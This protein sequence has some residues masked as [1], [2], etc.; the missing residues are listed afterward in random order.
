MTNGLIS[1]VERVDDIPLLLAQMEKIQLA[2]LLDNHFPMHGHWKGLGLGHIVQVWLAYILSEGDHR[3]NHV[4]SWAD[5]LQITLAKCLARPVRSLDFT[6]DRL[7]I[8]LDSLG[9]DDDFEAFERNLNQG[10][11]RVYDLKAKRV[12]VDSTSASGYM[13]V[14]ENGLF[15]FGHSKDHR[16]DLPQLKINQSALD[17]LGIPLTTTIVS[18][19]KA[20]D[21]LYIP[22]IRK[23]QNSLLEHGVLYVGDCK[24]ASLATRAYVAKSDDFYLCPL[25]SVQMPESELSLLLDKIWNNEQTLTSIYRPAVD[26][27]DDP[28]QIAEG[29]GYTIHLESDEAG[30]HFSWD[31]QRLVVRSLN[32]ARKQE[33]TLHAHIKEAQTVIAKLN[34]R[35]RGIK[36]LDEKEMHAAVDTILKKYKLQSLLQIEYRREEK[37]TLQK[38]T[39]KRETYILVETSITVHSTLNQDALDKYVRNLGWRVYACNDPALSIEEAVL[40]YRQEYLIEHGFARYKGKALGLTPI[41]LSS[42]TRIKGLV[43]LLSIGLRILCLLEFSVRET[44]QQKQEKLS[45]IYKG[46]PKRATIRPTAEVMLNVF[47]GISLVVLTINGVKYLEI[48]PLTPVQN[49]ILAFLGFSPTCYT[50][51][52]KVPWEL[53]N[54]YSYKVAPG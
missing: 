14:M 38:A 46:N 7:A 50:I 43:R 19:E 18:G 54:E 10:I 28:E 11:I 42:T 26:E 9:Q 16:P 22:E 25:S 6:D 12:R 40:A 35:G 39:R 1:T 24:M 2:P 32:H 33:H 41:Y 37:K 49:K 53:H 31:E 34:Q 15:Q 13:T 3:L 29:Y 27:N 45:G 20:D 21:P 5:S 47:R 48:T 44:L 17:P 4:E 8:V 52:C 51:L 36:T 30:D 23:V